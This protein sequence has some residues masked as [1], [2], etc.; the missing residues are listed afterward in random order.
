ME[1]F[2]P[3][4]LQPKTLIILRA[5]VK[6]TTGPFFFGFLPL[7]M[8]TYSP[9]KHARQTN[10]QTNNQKKEKNLPSYTESAEKNP[11]KETKRPPYLP[12]FSLCFL[13]LRL[14]MVSPKHTL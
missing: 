5:I 2:H 7:K 8:V 11:K 10:R 1:I 6:K 12:V 14:E 9:F 4:H 3:G 13:S